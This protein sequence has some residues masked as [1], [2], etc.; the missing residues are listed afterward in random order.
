MRSVRIARDLS[1]RFAHI[2]SPKVLTTRRESLVVEIRELLCDCVWICCH[3]ELC[4]EVKRKELSRCRARD[5]HFIVAAARSLGVGPQC[6]ILQN[7][8][9]LPCAENLRRRTSY[10]LSNHQHRLHPSILLR[11]QPP[12]PLASHIP[13]LMETPLFRRHRL[14]GS[15]TLSPCTLTGWEARRVRP[16]RREHRL[17]I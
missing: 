11:H 13:Q 6:P 4:L 16:L 17:S 10:L 5:W 3:G 7:N 12:R 14:H 9:D 8:H 2:K 15:G 1:C